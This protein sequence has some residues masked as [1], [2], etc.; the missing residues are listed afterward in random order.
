MSKIFGQN[1]GFKIEKIIIELVNNKLLND[2]NLNYKTLIKK[3]FNLSDSCNPIVKCFKK[4][5]HGLEKKTDL[6]FELENQRINISVKSGSA[7]SVHQEKFESFLDFLDSISQL[8]NNEKNLIK[9][10]HWC[11][12]TIENKGLVEDRKPKKIY[13]SLHR[14][15]FDS[16]IKILRRYKKQIF[17][18]AWVGS[19]NP[20][21]YLIY[22][23]NISEINSPKVI[24]FN[25]FLE[26]HLNYNEQRGN[27]GLLTIQNWNACLQGQDH[28]DRSSKHRNDVQFKTKDI[29]DFFL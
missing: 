15:R 21:D 6:L 1:K 22:I 10:F 19:K 9:E 28:C 23:S 5:G 20:P 25:D 2:I 4:E 16:Y 13:A 3:I 27:I 7:N 14:T 11:D 24:N 17:L 12:G 29:K 18:R 26:A 8:E